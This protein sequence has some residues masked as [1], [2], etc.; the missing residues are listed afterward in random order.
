VLKGKDFSVDENG[1]I[2]TRRYDDLH[3]FARLW[4]Q[5][6]AVREIAQAHDVRLANATAGGDLDELP[7]V[8]LED[9]VG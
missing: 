8:R 5:Y 9:L 6:R 3:G 7:R 2:L 4:R 1:N